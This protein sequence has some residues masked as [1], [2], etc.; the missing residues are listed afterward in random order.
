MFANTMMPGMAF[1]FPDV[2]LTPI[3]VPVPIPYP[4]FAL[5]IMAVPA[6]YNVLVSGMP[7]LNM[8]S[9]VP[10]TLADEPGIELGVLSGM[11]MGPQR[12][13]LGSF[14]TLVDGMPATRL[15][16]MTAHN[17]IG[18]NAPGL[19]IVPSQVNLLVLTP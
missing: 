6:A 9:I 14:T 19:S 16:S 8:S 7:A 13:L 2:C 11:V 4:N 17:G 10:L 12:A 5:N 3:V 1:G 18:L 15:T